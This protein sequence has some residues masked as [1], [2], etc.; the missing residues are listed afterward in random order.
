MKKI[1]HIVPY[2]LPDV[3]FGGPVF[4]VSSLCEALAAQ[5]EDVTV[6]TI[7]YKPEE[8]YPFEVKLNGVNVHYFK[9]DAG[10]P[11]QVSFQ[12]WKALRSNARQFDIVHLHT[13][14][15]VL[16]FQSIRLLST[17]DVP[18]VI[19][20][21]GMLSDYSFSHRKTSLK[22]YFQLFAGE[23]LVEGV[24]LHGTSAAEASE[25]AYR[26]NRDQDEVFVMP[27]LLNLSPAESFE[28]VA[29][30]FSLGFLSRIHHKKGIEVL[31]EAVARSPQVKKLVIGGRGEEAYEA[32]LRQKISELG[33]AGRIEFAGWVSEGQKADF[34]RRFQIFILPSYN[35]N[36]ANVV[37][38]AWAA[39]KPVIVS[40]E[41]GLS[42]QVAV[43]DIGWI[44]EPKV[45][46][47][48]ATIARA[49]KERD[50]WPQMG[51]FAIRLVKKSF[52]DERIIRKY[53]AMYNKMLEKNTVAEVLPLQTRK[54]GE[55]YILGINAHHADASAAIFRN[56]VLLAA[57]EEERMR[58]VKHWAG[59][60]THAVNFCLQEA[61]I[62][63]NEIDT[64][65]FGRDVYAK[66]DRK[67]Q[68]M[69]SYP[70]HF[71]KFM[72][73]RLS[74]AAGS[75]S[76]ERK[77]K[78]MAEQSGVTDMDKRLIYV[79]HHR[80]HLASA[81]Y[82][83]GWDQAA[84]LS[85]DGSGDFTTC[86]TGIGKGTQIEVLDSVDFPH[87]LGVFYT[88]F[89]Q[90]LGFPYYGDEYK[91]MGLA[92][93]GEPRYVEELKDMLILEEKGRFRLNLRYFRN[94]G[95]GYISYDRNHVPIVPPL[96]S[97]HLE[98]RFGNKRK[99]GEALTQHHKDLA[100]SLQHATEETIF[101]I[102]N[103]LHR[104][105][106]MSRL[107]LAGGVAQNS[108]AN[109]KIIRNT[110]FSEVFI[111]P[112]G[113]DAGLALGAG[114]YARHHML[115]HAR[116]EAMVHAY[117]GSYF[118]NAEIEA[119]LQRREVD[120]RLLSDEALFPAVAQAIAGGQVVG[121][122]RGRSEFGPRALG[123]RSILADP[124]RSDARE[125]LNLKI[126]RR[127]S[128]RPFA[129]SVLEEFA[130]EFFEYHEP[131]PFMEKVFTIRPE[132]RQVI[133][134]VTH[135]DGSGRI[136]TVSKENNPDYYKLIHIFRALTGIPL[137]LNTSFNESEPIVNTPQQAL[138]CFERTQMDM[139]VI[140][141]C[142]I[143]R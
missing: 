78:R 109:G 86:M 10:R 16:I 14:W 88:A 81:F 50:L 111:P 129:P 8:N 1:L 40:N 100:A 58:R 35:E 118:S 33:I 13:W 27:N 53:Q 21:R 108:V 46:S 22:K 137:L 25:M 77:L 85:V 127:E 97:R 41:V 133:P 72:R 124:R 141:N 30:E 76:V 36:F 17:M 49:W 2:Y 116:G 5:G 18:M 117:T 134:A 120:Y 132:K 101:H 70:Q 39:G 59:F 89:T 140:G 68:F 3:V 130:D 87:S 126:K 119:F 131:S 71:G 105:T 139:L 92:P 135:V 44:C 34:F 69:F 54:T 80:S 60:P 93:Y 38:E 73:G 67:I 110:P 19:S 91:V 102:L 112:A 142:M 125:L 122:F 84:L 74:N 26:T 98:K 29:G 128:F 90:L 65:A 12:L 24:F 113:H 51:N 15:N 121:W 32:S 20:P 82:L 99:A 23:R 94:P 56:G 123:N 83:S 79:E 63:W 107:C 48:V 103:H 45:E 47:V 114:L 115:G 106:G 31:L 75:G 104:Q 57:I 66:W 95:Q 4:S 42:E 43:N 55:Q 64:V 143:S 62:N 136:Q 37:A 11:C 6:Y 9:R 52:T 138:D 7:G 61:G 28:P 96:F